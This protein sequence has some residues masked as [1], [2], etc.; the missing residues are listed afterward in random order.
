MRLLVAGAPL[1]TLL[2][3]APETISPI[4]GAP[5]SIGKCDGLGAIALTCLVDGDTYG[6]LSQILFI[7]GF[8]LVASG[9]VPVVTGPLHY[10]LAWS[11]IAVLSTTDGGDQTALVFAFWAMPICLVDWRWHTWSAPVARSKLSGLRN[12]TE[13]V[14]VIVLRIQIAFIYLISAVFKFGEESWVD[15]TSVYYWIHS[16]YFA[17]PDWVTNLANG[18]T[19]IPAFML[20]M[21]WGAIAL[22]LLLAVSLF[23]SP[24]VRLPLFIAAVGFHSAIGV[25]FGIVSFS[26]TMVAMLLTLLAPLWAVPWAWSQWRARKPSVTAAASAA[27]A[28]LRSD[29][30]N[31]DPSDSPSAS[32]GPEPVMSALP[33]APTR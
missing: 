30:E 19:D 8:T 1:L 10:Y 31:S 12:S 33:L 14:F 6:W 32:T 22:E 26:L 7:V 24:K 25:L 28:G 20:A 5:G 4:T 27:S 11:W 9:V 21:T 17:R 29:T 15:G 13:A 16:P 2:T 18:L 3:N 23:L